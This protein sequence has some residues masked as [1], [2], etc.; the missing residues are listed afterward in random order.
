MF[1]LLARLYKLFLVKQF[2][3]R[4]Q[5]TKRTLPHTFVWLPL[6]SDIETFSRPRS[7]RVM[8]RRSRSCISVETP[9]PGRKYPRSTRIKLMHPV[10]KSANIN[11]TTKYC[12]QRA[13]SVE[14]SALARRDNRLNTSARRLTKKSSGQR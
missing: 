7:G 6:R 12:N 2:L 14:Q 4:L 3:L 10:A 8:Y 13:N 5:L 1:F 9:S 11:Q